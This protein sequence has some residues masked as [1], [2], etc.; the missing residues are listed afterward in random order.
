V[1]EEEEGDDVWGLKGEKGRG[2][3]RAEVG[4]VV[5]WGDVECVEECKG[6]DEFH[7]YP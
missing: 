5:K 7:Y 3:V 1:C 4:E 6:G 2:E